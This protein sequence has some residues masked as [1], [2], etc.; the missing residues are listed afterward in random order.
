MN[1]KALA[2]AAVLISGLAV[3]AKAQ[4]VASNGDLILGFVPNGSLASGTT[5]N[6][7][8][9]LGNAAAFLTA[10]PGTYTIGVSVLGSG[11][12]PYP[13]FGSAAFVIR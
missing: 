8:I 9:D 1:T 2:L 6:I 12:R 7:E 5:T 10:G 3:S 13:P 11:G 4:Q